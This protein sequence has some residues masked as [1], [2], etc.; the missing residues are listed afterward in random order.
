LGALLF[1]AIITLSLVVLLGGT[2]AGVG[3]ILSLSLVTLCACDS[4]MH[5][6]HRV[7][8]AGQRLTWREP[9][10]SVKC[11]MSAFAFTYVGVFIGGVFR[12][13]YL[14]QRWPF[15]AGWVPIAFCFVGYLTGLSIAHLV[16]VDSRYRLTVQDVIAD[17][18]GFALGVF[19]VM[20]MELA[21]RGHPL[22]GLSYLSRTLLT[23]LLASVLSTVTGG[24]VRTALMLAPPRSTAWITNNSVI[25]YWALGPAAGALS[26]FVYV[27]FSGVFWGCQPTLDKYLH[28]GAPAANLQAVDAHLHG[29]FFVV[30]YFMFGF[31]SAFIWL[32]IR[33]RQK[34]LQARL[35]HQDQQDRA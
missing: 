34:I 3:E 5:Y 24:V 32:M 9:G 12:D 18:D 17:V 20:G 30:L 21:T 4:S 26:Y 11:L 1:F 2:Y 19:A 8:A 15:A 6:F 35:N 27:F 23:V 13:L 22:D 25:L 31:G 33:E 10:F 7:Q 29:A 28:M 16:L 14:L